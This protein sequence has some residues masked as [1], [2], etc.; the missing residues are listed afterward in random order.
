MSNIS[1]RNIATGQD[2][3]SSSLSEEYTIT[4]KFIGEH[5]PDTTKT[6]D[7]T[8]WI[9]D[10]ITEFSEKEFGHDDLGEL[11]FEIV[12]C[13]DGIDTNWNKMVKTV[14]HLTEIGDLLDESCHIGPERVS[15]WLE[16]CDD[17]LG[18][19]FIGEMDDYCKGYY[20]SVDTYIRESGYAEGMLEDTFQRAADDPF[21]K[22]DW[23]TIIVD[24]GYNMTECNG[25]IFESK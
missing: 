24:L 5:E 9:E 17:E 3:R 8:G 23:D 21:L 19:D 11:T 20:G 14:D 12:A 16:F 22:I 10:Q 1:E 13:S 18:A 7:F 6:F 4:L 15:A 2:L 25:F